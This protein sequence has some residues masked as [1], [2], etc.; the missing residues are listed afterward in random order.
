ML[1][2]QFW[3]TEGEWPVVQFG[4]CI[5]TVNDIGKNYTWQSS[6]KPLTAR[7]LGVL[8]HSYKIPLRFNSM[9]LRYIDAVDLPSGSGISVQSF[10]EENFK[11]KLQREYAVA[12]A[13]ND[14]NITEVYILKD[15]TKLHLTVANGTHG[16]EKSPAIIWQTAVTKSASIVSNDIANWL[17]MVHATVSILF[18]SMLKDHFYESFSKLPGS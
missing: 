4:P 17:E 16:L 13:L 2:H 15:G 1:V 7:M 18:K 6:F 10:I 14:I 12:G 8:Q 11:L 5:M 9:S 3:K